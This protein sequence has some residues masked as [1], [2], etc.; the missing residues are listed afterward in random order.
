M[1]LAKHNKWERDAVSKICYK[2][3][4]VELFAQQQNMIKEQEARL[5]IFTHYLFFQ[6]FNVWYDWGSFL[7]WKEFKSFS[8]F[9]NIPLIFNKAVGLSHAVNL[10]RKEWKCSYL[11]S[12][13]HLWKQ[14]RKDISSWEFSWSRSHTYSVWLVS[15]QLRCIHCKNTV[16]HCETFFL[17]RK[18]IS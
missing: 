8:F 6:T 4:L 2:M 1:L 3:T 10:I 16:R 14:K 7:L 18:C 13:D 5:F 11:C 15:K 12:A 17:F 9:L